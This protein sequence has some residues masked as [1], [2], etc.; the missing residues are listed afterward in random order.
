MR[1]ENRQRQKVARLFYSPSLSVQCPYIKQFVHICL[2]NTFQR[3][4]TMPSHSEPL[5]LVPGSLVSLT[6]QPVEWE[7]SNS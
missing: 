2:V 3:I 6:P 5:P 1:R 7:L 4:A